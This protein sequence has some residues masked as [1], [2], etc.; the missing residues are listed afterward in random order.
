MVG[1]TFC[2]DT[3][4]FVES[5]WRLYPQDSFPTFWNKMEEAIET[6][7]IISPEIVLEE[8]K[9]QDDDLFA[10][11]RA[12]QDS[13]FCPLDIDLQIAQTDIVN[14]FPKLT[15]QLRNRSLADPWV[16]ALAQLKGCPVVSMENH[17]SEKKPKI[18][19]VCFTLGVGHM[20]VVE[21]IRTMKWRF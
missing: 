2:L 11:A 4:A 12:R 18:P 20:P 10:W 9:R 7:S 21:F 14:K 3:S 15:Q 16:V 17:G 6:G 5:W 19:D 13:L 1:S 8:L